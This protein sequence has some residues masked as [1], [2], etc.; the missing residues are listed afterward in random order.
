LFVYNEQI[1]SRKW[2]S[3]KLLY[4]VCLVCAKTT[5]YFTNFGASYFPGTGYAA[6]TKNGCQT[7]QENGNKKG[8]KD[9][10]QKT[11]KDL[12]EKD[13]ENI[14]KQ[15]EQGLTGFLSGEKATSLE[16]V[17]ALLNSTDPEFLC[18]ES[19]NLRGSIPYIA[20]FNNDSEVNQYINEQ[21]SI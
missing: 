18:A 9:K 17:K 3:R 11:F 13:K 2:Y 20:K 15:Y 4:D 19:D 12:S 8:N 21:Y 7:Q 16:Y 14:A 1:I 10:Q 5:F 6:Q